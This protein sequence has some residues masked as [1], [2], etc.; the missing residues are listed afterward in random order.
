MLAQ[1][2]KPVIVRSVF[3]KIHNSHFYNE[4]GVNKISFDVA[5]ENRGSEF[6]EMGNSSFLFKFPAG[7]LS[8]PIVTFNEGQLSGYNTLVKMIGGRYLMVQY[9]ADGGGWVIDSM[10]EGEHI[11]SVTMDIEELNKF[12][13][14][15]NVIDSAVVDRNLLLPV[16]NEFGGR[17]DFE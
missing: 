8:N 10:R 3:C 17:F 7:S 9:F 6:V 4:N 16:Q 15:W 5:I 1:S 11:F 14:I 12:Y 13:L 2:A